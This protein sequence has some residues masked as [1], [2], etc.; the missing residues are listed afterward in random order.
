MCIDVGMVRP[1]EGVVK[2]GERSKSYLQYN[3]N[4]NK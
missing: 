3:Y 2:F 4:S 1:K